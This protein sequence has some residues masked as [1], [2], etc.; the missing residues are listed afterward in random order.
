MAIAIVGAATVAGSLASGAMSANAAGKAANQQAGS[1][2][3]AQQIQQDEFNQVQQNEAPYNALGTGAI[4]SLQ[5]LND[6]NYNGFQNA[7]DY[8]FTLGQGENKI[9]QGAAARGNLFTGGNSQD[10]ATFNQ[11][12]A[13]QYLNN[14]RNS[15]MQQIGVGQSAAS[16][17]N[18]A[19]TNSANNQSNEATA[20]GTAQAGGT[21]NSANAYGNALSQASSAAGQYASSYN[22]NTQ[23]QS[24]LNQNVIN[25]E[26]QQ[27]YGGG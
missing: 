6:G 7:P 8:Q 10:L 20:A 12:T 17:T 18:A 14:Y 11:G 5:A 21:I 9:N 19:G 24:V 2:A 13:S 3:A 4:G 15:L 1:E 27:I 25:G 26:D 16:A 23:N 22:T